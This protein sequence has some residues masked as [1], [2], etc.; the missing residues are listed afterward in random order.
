MGDKIWDLFFEHLQKIMFPE[1]WLAMGLSMSRMELMALLLIWVNG[2]V[3]MTQLAERLDIPMSTATGVISRLAKKG[4]VE[5]LI[6]ESNR[7]IVTVRLTEKGAEI[8]ENIK[9]TVTKYIDL[10]LGLLSDQE[11][12]V[13]F[14]LITKVIAI[15]TGSVAHGGESEKTVKSITIE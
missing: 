15:F 13:L 8:P 7:R 11:K 3:I 4:Y 9:H 14:K 1:L 2:E 6:D 10:I 5:R 12:D